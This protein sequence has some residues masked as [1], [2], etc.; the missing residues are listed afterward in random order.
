MIRLFVDANI[1]LDALLQRPHEAAAA[2]GLLELG[3][4]R[5]VK[6][7]TTAISIG[8]VLYHLQR[9]GAD[10][11]GKRLQ[12][13]RHITADL[14]A[15]L[16]VVP[17]TAEHFLQST[18]SSFTDIEDGAQYFAVAATGP[19]TGVVSRDPDFDG[20][21]AVKRLSA[22]AAVALVTKG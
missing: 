12:M 8:I 3:E 19:L 9:S 4:K 17:V 20:H 10:K 6:L 15:C 2:I 13:A 22:S 1:L 5:R 11:K 18:A 21:I 14:L 16:E 7:L